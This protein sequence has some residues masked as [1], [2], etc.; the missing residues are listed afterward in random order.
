MTQ[1]IAEDSQFSSLSCGLKMTTKVKGQKWNNFHKLEAIKYDLIYCTP[2]FSTLEVFNI[3]LKKLWLAILD[4]C[5]GFWVTWFDSKPQPILTRLELR[6]GLKTRKLNNH[7]RYQKLPP[8][9]WMKFI[10][11]HSSKLCLRQQ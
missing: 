9:L 10:R 7:H 5:L 6:C 3:F 1:K 2:V 4:I 8:Q 11:D